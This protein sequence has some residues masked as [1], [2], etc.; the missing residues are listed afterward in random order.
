MAVLPEKK[1]ENPQVTPCEEKEKF[2]QVWVK[3]FFN[4]FDKR[5][6]ESTRR[7]I[8]YDCGKECFRS[9]LEGSKPNEVDIDVLIDKIDEYAVENAAARDGSVVDFRYVK[10]SRGLRFAD[11]YCLCPLVESGPPGLSRTYCDC[12]VGYVKEMFESYTGRG[13]EVELVESLK[14][15]GRGCR[16]RIVLAS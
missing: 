10:N 16:F 1:P 2:A 15:G 14:R 13:A 9:S 8:M 11:G 3:R 4:N 6:N 12:S 5:L 7:E